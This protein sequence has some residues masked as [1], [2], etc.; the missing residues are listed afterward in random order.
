MKIAHLGIQRDNDLMYYIKNGD[1]WATPRKKP[2]Q[3]KGKAQK[4]ASAGV[5]M[6]YS[7]YIY[8]LDSDGDIAAKERASGGGGRKAKAPKAPKAP[9][10]G[11][12]SKSNGKSARSAITGHY[13]KEATAMRHPDTTIQ[14]TR[15]HK[16]EE[17]IARECDE[18]LA[19]TAPAMAGARKKS[20]Y[21][22]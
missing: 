2:G 1:V 19:A 13:V 22:Y 3:P 9:R 16:S 7:K 12:K 4:I 8:F 6:D 10:A 5:D 17:Q 14:E 21:W 15:H 11:K 18:A 20:G